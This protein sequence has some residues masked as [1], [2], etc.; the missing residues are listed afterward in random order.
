MLNIPLSL[1]TPAALLSGLLCIVACESKGGDSDGS[2]T[3]AGATEGTT[4]AALSTGSVPTGST[5][6]TATEPSDG[7][8]TATG[9]ACD[10]HEIVDA[11][12]CFELDPGDEFTRPVV[13]IGCGGSQLCPKVAISCE[14]PNDPDG[15][16]KGPCA[17]TADEAPLDCALAALAAGEP[18]SLNIELSGGIWSETLHYYLRGD[19]TVFHYAERVEDSYLQV[20]AVEH[21]ALKP[22][23]FFTD[24]S[25]MDS[26]EAKVACLQDAA[27]GEVFEQCTVAADY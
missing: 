26:V 3:D 10:E 1:S 7:T 22:P 27:A 18:G 11:C 14:D 12:C 5:M 19:G 2:P 17:S 4:E 23:S 8:D 9:G 16:G 25:S 13:E 6:E 21:R 24:C 15:P 20:E